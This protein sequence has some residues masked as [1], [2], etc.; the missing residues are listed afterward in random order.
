MTYGTIIWN[1]RGSVQLDTRNPTMALYEKNS[2]TVPSYGY[3]PSVDIQA[4]SSPIVLAHKAQTNPM[5]C[6]NVQY[7]DGQYDTAVVVKVSGNTPTFEYITF[8][9]ISE[10]SD[11]ASYG[12]RIYDE[13]GKIVFRDDLPSLLRNVWVHHSSVTGVDINVHDADNNYFILY[14]YSYKAYQRTETTTQIYWRLLKY[15]DSSTV[16]V[17]MQEVFYDVGFLSSHDSVDAFTLVE[18]PSV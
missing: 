15:V 11:N 10:F 2:V 13:D 1:T 6:Q 3:D 14:P 18:I 4:T 8:V 16:N 12:M 7:N 9:P 17:S 5:Q